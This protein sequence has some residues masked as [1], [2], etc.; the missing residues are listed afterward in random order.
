MDT[1]TTTETV[2]RPFRVDTPE[3]A[4]AELETAATLTPADLSVQRD[5]GDLYTTAG[6]NDKA[7]TAYRKLLAAHADDAQ[8]HHD[9]GKA[10]LREK[11]YA[12][13]QQE[14]ITAVKLKPDL[15][16]AYGDLAFA[17]SVDDAQRADRGRVGFSS[18]F[19]GRTLPSA[20]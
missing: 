2:V 8:L 5:L 12:E 6:K 4:I 1:Q 14:F 9:L 7:E 16:P 11:K 3:E 15:G 17:A 10:L 20:S 19:L 18:R 13:A